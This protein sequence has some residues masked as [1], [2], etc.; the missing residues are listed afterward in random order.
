MTAGGV[1]EI[2]ETAPFLVSAEVGYVTD[3]VIV[4]DG[5]L[6]RTL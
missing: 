3:Q 4:A 2:G 5:G 1:D 6:N